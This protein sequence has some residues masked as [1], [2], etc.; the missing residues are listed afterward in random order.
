[1][2]FTVV[3]VEVALLGGF[4]VGWVLF[5]DEGVAR[6]S[7]FEDIIRTLVRDGPAVVD[8]GRCNETRCD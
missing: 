7:K 4:S 3:E 2:A 5:C 8:P 6:D 1:L